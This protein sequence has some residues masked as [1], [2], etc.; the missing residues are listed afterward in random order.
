MEVM[1]K[2][3]PNK[4]A[5]KGGG[6]L[7]GVV[8]KT[9]KEKRKEARKGKKQ[10]KQLYLKRRFGR[11]S[12]EAAEEDNAS[13]A[14]PI[15]KAKEQKLQAQKTRELKEKERAKKIK[16]N[17]EKLRKR[18]LREDNEEEERNLR[19]L[20]KQLHMNKRKNQ[21]TLPKS[22]L[23]DGLDFL[24]DAVDSE[25]LEELREK[26]ESSDDDSDSDNQ[27]NML[28]EDADVI[29]NPE[30]EEEDV[31]EESE[32]EMDFGLDGS[33]EGE[34]DNDAD[35]A[36][37]EAEEDKESEIDE[38]EEGEEDD[39]K[40]KQAQTWEDIYG[41]TRDE[42]G[43]VIDSSG[44]LVDTSTR[45]LMS[46]SAPSASASGKYIPPALRAKMI[47]GDDAKR[48]ETL[49]RL[50]KKVKG[51][52]NRLAASNL[53]GISKELER[54]YSSHSRNDMNEC[55][56]RLYKDALISP[57]LTPERLIMEHALLIGVLHCNVGNEVGATLMQNAVKS[58]HEL[59]LNY[60]PPKNV[61][62][63]TSKELENYLLFLCFLYTFKITD[64]ELIFDILNL[65]ADGFQSK[66][67]ELIVLALRTI[68]FSLRKDD[69]ARLKEL[70]LKI[71]TNSS[72]AAHVEKSSRI[73]FMLEILLAIRNNNVKKIPNYDSEHQQFLLKNMKA[74]LRP[75]A[76]TDPFKIRMSDLLRADERGR[77]WVVGSAWA[78]KN[79]DEEAKSGKATSVGSSSS[80]SSD[81]L[82]LAR[83]MR[84]NTETRK[85]IF[86]TVMAA[87][88][89]LDAFEKLLKM[90][91][92]SQ[93]EREIIFVLLDCCLQ[94]QNFNPYYPQLSVKLA[95]FDRKY[96]LAAQFS[97]WDRIKE[98]ESLNAS[99]VDNLAKY[100]GFLISNDALS[101]ACL[102]VI[103]FADL[104]KEYVK[105]LKKVLKILLAER[106][107]AVK[108]M[109]LSVAGYPKLKVLREGLKLFMR[110][111][112]L[113]GEKKQHQNLEAKIEVAEKALNSGE[114][115]LAL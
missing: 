24:L 76:T 47:G 44:A 72:K 77:W 51:L 48:K 11:I 19:Q 42:K 87:E 111:F 55:L 97:V 83:K 33:S 80:Y 21:K 101:I 23:D 31:E 106:D 91:I 102:K 61:A 90:V 29:T 6:A 104:S 81:L 79:E 45:A 99:Q 74:W 13:P 36:K 94:E 86:C 73:K 66:D 65:L 53:A 22:F 88:D 93:K 59:Y 75:G 100:L 110:H 18:K 107:A 92:K 63:E 62:D 28:D 96:R 35:L 25:K 115:R 56:I 64:S 5:K 10:Q 54:L 105:F 98:L 14:A 26:G 15:S 1:S 39:G 34:S 16:K 70:I 89:Y 103:E 108:K 95:I 58:F 67:V 57:V 109:F 49:E 78:G 2:T 113:K 27:P 17:A 82:D 9:R 85:N 8:V 69:P 50:G 3:R 41:R 46:A 32:E 40:N 30:E 71:Q 7:Q 4:A 37:E 84:M 60:E 52:L 20:A 12:P 112:M 38:E 68:G 43:N 114:K